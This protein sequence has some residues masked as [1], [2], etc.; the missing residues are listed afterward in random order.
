M[1]YHALAFILAISGFLV[2]AGLCSRGFFFAGD[3]D[4]SQASALFAKRRSR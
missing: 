1:R 2:C 4:E 3:M